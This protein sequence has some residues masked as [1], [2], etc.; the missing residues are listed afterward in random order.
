LD[1]LS[2]VWEFFEAVAP[3]LAKI[4]G[5]FYSIYDH[6][7]ILVGVIILLTLIAYFVWSKWWPL[8]WPSRVLRIATLVI[9][10]ILVAHIADPIANLFV[11]GEGRKSAEENTAKTNVAPPSVLRPSVTPPDA[12]APKAAQDAA[13]RP[14]ASASLAPTAASSPKLT[15]L[16]QA[17]NAV[18]TPASPN[19]IST[20]GASANTTH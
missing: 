15:D 1:V 2:K 18:P 17:A 20:K 14:A 8:V 10:V 3:W 11:P 5:S 6:H 12:T 9:A 7:P 13:V 4:T 16:S 19:E